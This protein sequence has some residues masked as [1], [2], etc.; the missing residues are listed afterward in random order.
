MI[1]VTVIPLAVSEEAVP[2]ESEAVVFLVIRT[3]EVFVTACDEPMSFCVV[4]LSISSADR[5]MRARNPAALVCVTVFTNKFLAAGDGPRQM[6]PI[7]PKKRRQSR[8]SAAKR[9]E[10][11]RK[12]KHTKRSSEQNLSGLCFRAACPEPEAGRLSCE[13]RAVNHRFLEIG[14]RLPE[15]LRVLEPNMRERISAK[16]SRGKLDVSMRIAGSQAPGA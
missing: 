8:K 10:N 11:K 15:E 12:N 6:I 5:Y 1:S 14:F 3:A 13:L 16:V 4:M 2:A 7:T 9:T